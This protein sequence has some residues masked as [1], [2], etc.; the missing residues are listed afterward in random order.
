MEILVVLAIGVMLFLG[1]RMLMQ[2]QAQKL[3]D[4]IKVAVTP[5]NA[6]KAALAL[7][8]EQHRELYRAIGAEDGRRALAIF[9]Q[10]TGAPIKDC[11]IA[12]QALHAH[13][14]QAPSELRAEDEMNGAAGG[15]VASPIDTHDRP[16]PEDEVL[17]GELVEDAI[18]GVR[19]DADS[20][21]RDPSKPIGEADPQTGEILG[22]NAQQIPNIPGGEKPRRDGDAP[23]DVDERAKR[24]M[25]ESGFNPE[26]EL[27]IPADWGAEE[28]EIAGF[29]LEV[30]RGTEK[31][32]LS[33]DDLEP[34]VHDQLYALL[35]DDLVDEAAE[36]LSA[37][38]P[39]TK[40]EA[41]KFLVV[42]KNQT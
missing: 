36:L 34:W 8:D 17:D 1:I 28:E 11:I 14:Q 41:R 2:R 16:G 39:L 12:V 13:P 31:I 37:H 3:N 38:S 20:S 18:D 6:R 5:E 4:G 21:D 32:T 22:E 27:T 23:R 10:S 26:D 30:Q 24:L 42:F 9:K 40:E 7:S 35:R 25:D 15:A 33:H 19:D 29:H